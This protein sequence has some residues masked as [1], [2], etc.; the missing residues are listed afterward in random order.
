MVTSTVSNHSISPGVLALQLGTPLAPQVLDVRRN[1]AF[2]ASDQ[3]LATATHCPPENVADFA[4]KHPRQDIVVYCVYGHEV[5]QQAARILR[6]AGL[7]ARYLAGGIAG[8]EDGADPAPH[9]ADWRAVRP[10]TI[11]KRP[12]LGVSGLSPSRWITRERPKI[13]R[14]ACPWLIRR[15]IDPSA[16]FLYV[17]TSQVMAQAAAQQAVAFDIPGAP[18]SHVGERCSFDTLLEAFGLEQDP[19]LRTLAQVVRAADTD[20]LDQSAQAA[21][22]LALSLG[23]SAQHASDDMAMLDAA[24]TLY[25]ALYAWARLQASGA[26]EGHSWRPETMQAAQA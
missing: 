7:N 20:Q 11:R 13:D 1:A 19:A 21:G 18:I 22:L 6:Q 2:A 25:D 23:L 10:L 3:M 4:A 8:G 5:S 9:I 17:P 24:M 26:A 15:F 14:V 12:D 16:Q